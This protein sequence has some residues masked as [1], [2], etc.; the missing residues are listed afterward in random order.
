MTV[1]V[2]LVVGQG[3]ST[4]KG[5]SSIGIST[6]ADK[7]KF[8]EGRRRADCIIIGGNTARNEPY[9]RTPVPVIVLS[10]SLVNPLPGN[11]LAHLWN[12][13][14]AQAVE[15]A[16]R[17][18]GPEIHLESGFSLIEEFLKADLIDRLELSETQIAGGD[19]YIDV[20]ELLARFEISTI[21]DVDGTRFTSAVRKSKN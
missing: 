11:H 12:L 10:R 4:S 9:Q 2:T 7:A 21:S 16:T 20:Q 15:R 3:G 19:D 18:F 13:N 6:P 5:G 14:P 8:L 17:L 1:T